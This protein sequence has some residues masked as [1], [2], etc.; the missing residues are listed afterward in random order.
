RSRGSCH[1]VW[2]ERRVGRRRGRGPRPPRSLRR[3]APTLRAR[4]TP[5]PSFVRR[6]TEE[7]GGTARL[8]SESPKLRQER[9]MSQDQQHFEEPD[10]ESHVHRHGENDEPADEGDTEIEAH[11]MKMPNVRMDLPSNT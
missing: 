10:V 11:I 8:G 6:Q 2:R 7:P 4:L 1:Q 3:A 9:E 5:G